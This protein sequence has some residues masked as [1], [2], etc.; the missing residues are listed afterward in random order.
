MIGLL[1]FC[2]LCVCTFLFT[3]TPGAAAKEP[4][5]ELVRLRAVASEYY[6]SGAYRDALEAAK[7]TIALTKA[8]FG[9]DSEE[10]YIQS[11]GA[12]LTA[13]AAQD[14]A[15][16]ERQFAEAARIGEIVYGKDNAG[17][18]HSFEQ[19]G[20]AILHEGRPEDAEAQ[21]RHALKIWRGT[22]GEHAIMADAYGGVGACRLARGDAQGAMQNYRQAVRLLKREPVERA[23]SRSV[24][25]ADI[26]RHRG[27]FLGLGRAAAALRVRGGADE[28]GL[29]DETFM[30]GQTAWATSAA[31]A[32]AKMTA[33]LKAQDSALGRAIRHLDELN[34]RILALNEA[35]MKALADWSRVQ[36]ADKEYREALEAFRSLSIERAKADAPTVNRQKELVARLQELMKQCPSARSSGCERAEAER[37]EISRELNALSEHMMKSAGAAMELNKRMTA[38]EQMLPGYQEFQ[39]TRHR[40]LAESERLEEEL[41]AQRTQVVK[42]FPD[43]LPLSEPAPLGVAELQTLLGPEQVLVA[44]L[45]GPESTMVWAVTRDGFDWA[46]V[47]AGEAVIAAE[48]KALRLGLDP[49]AVLPGQTQNFDAGRSYRLYRLLFGRLEPLISGKHHLIIVPAGPLSSLPFQVLVTEPPKSGLSSEEATAQARW[50]IRDHAV[51]VLPSVQSLSALK[52][53]REAGLAPKPFFGMGD[54]IFGGATRPEGPAP[55]RGLPLPTLESLYRSGTADLRLLESL[56]PLPETAAELQTVANTL[57][58]APEDVKLREEATKDKLKAARLTEYRVLHFATH[59]LVA[60][61]LSGVNEPALVLS[62]PPNTNDPQSL[63]LTASEVAT[64][65]LNAEWVVLSACNTAAGD[66]IGADALSGLARAF[67]FAGARALLVSHWAVNSEAAVKLTTRSFEA[68]SLSPK[69]GKAEAFRLA[70]ISLINEGYPPSSWAPFMIVGEAS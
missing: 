25:E 53:L 7:K 48:V 37:G 19:L 40:R 11:Y 69:A 35:D 32:L 66:K 1:R 15:E 58:A 24:T 43:Y 36:Q 20:S 63:L 31:S 39:T 62:L 49:L 9:P 5:P 67:F 3:G 30:A 57:H 45:T 14:F 16:A 4:S 61:D 22:L 27:I 18:G 55:G 46:E 13:E 54:P 23:L 34:T 10:A 38:R 8:E 12:G 64:L 28:T 33:R 2:A 41:S 70:M 6:K 50:F 17:V 56:A 68:L 60:G 42:S 29:M 52:K 44:V 26:K 47:N 21:F 59:G 65:S 51:S